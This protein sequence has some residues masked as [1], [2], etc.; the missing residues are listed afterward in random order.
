MLTVKEQ[1]KDFYVNPWLLRFANKALDRE[2]VLYS[3]A[4]ITKMISLSTGLG[5]ITWTIWQLINYIFYPTITI[6]P[7]SLCF[8]SLCPCTFLSRL[9]CFTSEA[10]TG[11]SL[12]ILPL[13][14]SVV[15]VFAFFL[16]SFQRITHSSSAMG[17]F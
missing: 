3:N 8:F 7:I 14:F 10:H 4:R 5:V 9:Y 16:L 11:Y 1:F 6:K 12:S 13:I 15:P 2:F 17:S